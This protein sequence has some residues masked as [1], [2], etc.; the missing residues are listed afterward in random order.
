MNRETHTASLVSITPEA[1]KQI[2]YMARVSNPSNQNNLETAP[3]LIKYLIKHKHWSP[4][5][6]ASMQVEIDTTRAIAAQILRHRS[7]SFQEFS[8]RYSSAGDLPG[9]GLPHLRSQD[10][11]NKQASHDDL[12]PDMVDLMNKQIQQIY[13]S[14]FDYYEYLLSKGVAK[15]CARSILPLGTPTRL[16]MSGSVRSWI[17]YIQ[18]RAGVETQLEHRLIAEAIKDIFEEQLPSV[19]EAAFT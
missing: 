9:I 12:D 15:E 5:E 10:L 18:I 6:M 19:Y 7:F 8:Q 1:E 13:H 2:V 14:T 4:F 17:H 16:Y 3:R 11:K